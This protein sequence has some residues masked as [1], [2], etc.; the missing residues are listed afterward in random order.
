MLQDVKFAVKK[1]AV[2][3]LPISIW[4][5][6]DIRYV[7]LSVPLDAVVNERYSLLEGAFDSLCRKVLES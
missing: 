5:P 3:V 4:R 2:I 1:F 7:G 6:C